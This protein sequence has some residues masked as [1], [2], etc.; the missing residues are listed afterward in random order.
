MSLS[1]IAS[2]STPSA[3]VRFDRITASAPSRSFTWSRKAQA[4]AKFEEEL[5]EFRRAARGSSRRH[6][7]EELGD[8]LCALVNVARFEKLDPEAALHA[9]VRKLARRI[10]GVEEQAR[11]RGR[12]ITQLKEA[13][14]LELWEAVKRAEKAAARGRAGRRRS[15]EGLRT[16]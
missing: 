13:E 4:W 3:V 12:A 8:L 16:R 11:A 15:R 1:A 10:A 6:K 5:G 7:A 14:L 2:T 9:G